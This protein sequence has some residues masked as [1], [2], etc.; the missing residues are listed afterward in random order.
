MALLDITLPRLG[1]TMD[2]GQLVQWLKAPGDWCERGEPLLE[3][4][5]DKTVV[6]LPSL[7]S[8]RLVE[9]VVHEGARV[10]VGSVIG[11][12]E[13]E[14]AAVAGADASPGASPGASSGVPPGVPPGVTP[15]VPTGENA[16]PTSPQ[17]A[18]SPAAAEAST[19][20][21]GAPSPAGSAAAGM[22]RATPVARRLANALGVRLDDVHGGGR[23]GRIEAS[24]VQHAA[25]SR[26]E[27][28]AAAAAAGSAGTFHPASTAAGGL[29]WRHWQ[30]DA[31]AATRHRTVVLLHGHAG[32]HQTWA[33][34]AA[35]LCRQ[36]HEVLAPDLP[37]HG[38]SL[39]E[40][41]S[42]DD[43][44]AP[45][46]SWLQ[47]TCGGPFE[48]VGHSLGA[49]A[50]VR[51]ASA[52]P[53]AER[54]TR[55]T[56]IAP[57]GLGF[58]I[59]AA[60]IRALASVDQVDA[61]RHLLQQLAVQPPSL[62]RPQLADMVA[63]LGPRGRL[64]GLAAS[65]AGSG[66]QQVDI[67]PALAALGARARVVVGLQDRVIPWHQVQDIG[68]ATALHLVRGAGHMVH[69]DQPLAVAALFA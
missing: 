62:S 61:M 12:I 5:T 34:L 33:V 60:F 35:Q 45:L 14:P 42:L 49:V 30:P 51:L 52:G 24:D 11:R 32:D 68:P 20:E 23:R 1:E 63:Q 57:A 54:C 48:L 53:A 67:K 3:L 37:A 16:P 50:A 56:L 41:A 40:A 29:A 66:M 65:L 44:Q 8:G 21:R 31:S 4:E 25:H 69:W 13:V 59:D 47:A 64:H 6:E 55:V 2:S 18:R 38:A 22:R 10:D 9:I 46:Q 28:P 39:A 17:D 58:D 7:V 19:S 43:L 27:P 36:G 15:G 26:A